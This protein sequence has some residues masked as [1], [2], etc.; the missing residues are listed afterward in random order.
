MVFQS[1]EAVSRSKEG[2]AAAGFAGQTMEGTSWGSYFQHGLHDDLE[3][4]V[5]SQP[6]QIMGRRRLMP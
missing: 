1:A 5:D 6:G 3:L 2:G 4:L